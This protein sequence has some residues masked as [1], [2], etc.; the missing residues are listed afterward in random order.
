MKRVPV[1]HVR[2]VKLLHAALVLLGWKFLTGTKPHFD[3]MLARL[4]IKQ[5][6]TSD[7]FDL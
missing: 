5:I 3:T 6:I 7:C 2:S 4:R 1:P